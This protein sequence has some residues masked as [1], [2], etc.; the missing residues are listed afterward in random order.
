MYSHLEIKG[1]YM[2]QYIF[3][4]IVYVCLLHNASTRLNNL[5][6]L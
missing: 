3:I 1:V 4:F 6:Y 2:R 5:K